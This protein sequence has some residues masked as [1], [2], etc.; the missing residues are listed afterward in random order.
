MR[1]QRILFSGNYG[2][3]RPEVL[4][5]TL[6]FVT[7]SIVRRRLADSASD[8]EPTVA[9]ILVVDDDPV[10]QAAVRLAP[11]RR[12]MAAKC[13]AAFA[14]ISARCVSIIPAG[15]GWI[16]DHEGTPQLAADDP[17]SGDVRPSGDADGTGFPDHGGQA[18]CDWRPVQTTQTGRL[19]GNGSKMSRL[20]NEIIPAT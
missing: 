19:A 12:D 2:R 16:G 1:S 4:A 20:A 11:V 7:S 15:Y 8:G 3:R 6:E 5:A 13:L 18:R 17:E 14:G 10:M 9:S